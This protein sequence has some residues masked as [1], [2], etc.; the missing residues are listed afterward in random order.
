MH[1]DVSVKKPFPVASRWRYDY[2]AILAFR[3]VQARTLIKPVKFGADRTFY[4]L[5]TTT[6]FPWRDIELCHATRDTPFNEN[7][8]SSQFTSK[9]FRLD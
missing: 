9:A 5:V 8:R 3:C 7:S 4:G 6:L 1:V 2:N